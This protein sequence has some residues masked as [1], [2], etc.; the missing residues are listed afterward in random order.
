MT[1]DRPVNHKTFWISAVLGGC[2]IVYGVIGLFAEAAQTQ[3]ARWMLWFLGAAIVHDLLI[4]PVVFGIGVLVHRKVQPPLRA[5]LQGAL[6]AS[7]M[8]FVIS[9]PALLGFGRDPTNPSVLPANYIAGAL[10]LFA[11]VWIATGVVIVFL[12]RTSR[13]RGEA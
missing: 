9:L 11:V 5:P 1:D 4:A 10:Q 7:A 3:P 8:L 2:V 6:I 12:R 13:G